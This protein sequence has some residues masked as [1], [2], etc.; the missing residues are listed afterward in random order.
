M[1]Y[2]SVTAAVVSSVLLFFA[3]PRL[4]EEGNWR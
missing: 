3:L 2:V 4:R 1:Y